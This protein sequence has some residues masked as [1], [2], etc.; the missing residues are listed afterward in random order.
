MAARNMSRKKQ[1]NNLKRTIQ[2][3]NDPND[4]WFID[5]KMWPEIKLPDIYSI[6]RFPNNV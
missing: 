4:Q 1:T 3:D 6:D 5:I 2:I